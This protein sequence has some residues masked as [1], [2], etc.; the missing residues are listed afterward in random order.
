MCMS[1]SFR[2]KNKIQDAITLPINVNVV[3]IGNGDGGNIITSLP[4]TEAYN[5]KLFIKIK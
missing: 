4:Y 5:I 1:T 3:V 2:N